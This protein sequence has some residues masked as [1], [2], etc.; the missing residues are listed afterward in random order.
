[1]RTFLLPRANTAPLVVPTHQYAVVSARFALALAGSKRFST[2]N[3][4]LY[5]VFNTEV[6]AHT[7]VAEHKLRLVTKVVPW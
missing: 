3:G 6:Q 1:M 4:K 2:S 7:Y 5:A